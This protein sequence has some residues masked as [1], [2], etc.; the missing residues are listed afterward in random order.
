MG[1]VRFLVQ[2]VLILSSLFVVGTIFGDDPWVPDWPLPIRVL[3]VILIAVFND[4]FQHNGL[5]RHGHH[6]TLWSLL[7]LG[8]GSGL[9]QAW[10]HHGYK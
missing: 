10:R 6:S 4:L 8:L 7:V 2:L 1:W 9:Y 5:K 3:V